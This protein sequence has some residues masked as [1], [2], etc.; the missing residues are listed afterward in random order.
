MK[1]SILLI[2]DEH[3]VRM[4][5]SELLD[6][7]GYKVYLSS[8]GIQALDFYRNNFSQVD[9]IILDMIM[10]G[11]RGTSVFKEIKS[12]NPNARVLF[13]SGYSQDHEIK[14]ILEEGALGYL[15]KPVSLDN[16]G[17]KIEAAFQTA[18]I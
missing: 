18:S 2:D 9:L 8:D 12:I 13:L 10:P 15:K 6:Y 7:L 1:K 11:M 4:I 5:T 3:I 17:E 16:L 14:E